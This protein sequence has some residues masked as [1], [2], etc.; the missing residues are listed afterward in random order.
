MKK[1]IISATISALTIFSL[2]ACTVATTDNSEEETSAAQAAQALYTDSVVYGANNLT[3]G[4]YY[5]HHANTNAY[6]PVYFG[7]ATF[8][9]GSKSSAPSNDRIMWFKTDFED[10]PTFYSGDELVL[11]TEGEITE[12]F[13]FERFED[14]GYTVGIAQMTTTAS[15]RYAISTSPNKHCT[16]PGGDTD[17]ILNLTNKQ[18]LLD[19]FGGNELRVVDDEDSIY[20]TRVGTIANLSKGQKYAA[21]IFDGT[22][23]HDYEFTADVH[24][25]GSMEVTQTTDYS[26]I[27]ETLQKIDVPYM[28]NTGYYMINGAGMFRYV[29]G[30]YYDD[31]TYYNNKNQIPTDENGK[32]LY[33]VSQ[34]DTSSNATATFE[35]TGSNSSEQTTT[36]V[37]SSFDVSQTGTVSMIVSFSGSG[38]SSGV[39]AILTKPSG[40][41]VSLLPRADSTMSLT[42]EAD[43]IGTYTI[44][45]YNL[46][47][48]IPQ[49]SF[50]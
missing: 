13:N 10:I 45:Y 8:D 15:G 1:R 37:S 20:L 19:S 25:L 29:Q 30:N 7:D 21:A 27:S 24:V 33:T 2:S 16:Y 36:S 32:T 22:I 41:R 6:E 28:F 18:V 42:F 35:S 44:T 14:F 38:S 4:V 26:F 12:T 9:E 47:S 34:I 5:I 17:A 50:F 31:Y 40:D 48:L 23:E 39:T 43:T 3:D 49:V 11:Y 46:G